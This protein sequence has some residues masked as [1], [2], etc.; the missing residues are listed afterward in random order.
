[1][2]REIRYRSKATALSL[3]LDWPV[4]AVPRSRR[5]VSFRAKAAA[6]AAAAGMAVVRLEHIGKRYDGG[7]QILSDVSL[8]L[9]PGGFYFLTGASGAGKTTLLK[10][11]YLA[12]RPSRGQLTLFGADTGALDR[13]GCSALRRRIGIVFQDFRLIDELSARE[14]VALPLRIA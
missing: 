11:V 8:T 4:P 1:M 12:E 9:E 13:L 2:L 3:R 6:G 10:I 5:L 7:A 14:N